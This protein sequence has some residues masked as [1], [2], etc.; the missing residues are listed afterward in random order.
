MKI[1]TQCQSL[2]DVLFGGV[3]T[4]CL[5]LLFGEAGTGKTNLCLQ[6]AR[7]IALEG[8]KIIFIDTEG[9][10]LE[11]LKQICKEDY[12]EVLKNILFSQPYSFEEQEKF[13]EKAAKLAENSPDIGLIVLDS[14]TTYY[15]LT[16]KDEERGDRK[17]LTRQIARLLKVARKEDIPILLTSQVYTD[18]E[19][20]TY[21][22]LGGHM[23]SHNAKAI[24]RLEKIGPSLRLAT[25]VKHRHLA[26]GRTAQFKLTD[27]G[28]ES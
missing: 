16:L 17:S 28:L 1:K 18:V 8:K 5:T 22:P 11:R 6:L 9:V 7:N 14:A 13:V 23:L 24:L 26:E 21:E 15:R 10:S 25:I 12:E 2:D 19:R 20:G 3:E 4:G 27:K